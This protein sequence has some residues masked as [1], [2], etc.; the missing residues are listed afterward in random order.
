MKRQLQ[1]NEKKVDERSFQE[2]WTHEFGF[3]EKKGKA[4]CIFCS[5]SVVFRTSSVKRHF[6][7]C[8]K[9]VLEKSVDEKKEI[10]SKKLKE[11]NVQASSLMKYVKSTNNITAASFHI[12][13]E[14]AK[15][16]W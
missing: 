10:I 4:Q 16:G 15:Q 6:E 3:V 1:T 8:H 7:T 11:I 12:S 14:I 2:S 9:W 13:F 5:E